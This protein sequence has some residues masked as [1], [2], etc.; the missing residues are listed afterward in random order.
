[1]IHTNLQL[2]NF[3]GTRRSTT[4]I[5]S[6]TTEVLSFTKFNFERNLFACLEFFKKKFSYFKQI[7]Y[8]VPDSQ[9]AQ[10]CYGFEMKRFCH[11][12]EIFKEN[13]KVREVYIIIEGEVG[14]LKSFSKV[15][16]LE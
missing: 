3:K 15:F 14:L 8:E 1:M 16:G 11:G 2:I 7:F 4:A 10:F 5:A 9:L 6:K 13:D 12:Q